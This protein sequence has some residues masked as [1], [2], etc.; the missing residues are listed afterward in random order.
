MEHLTFPTF[1]IAG[2]PGTIFCK[3]KRKINPFLFR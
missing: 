2:N 3:L 1:A